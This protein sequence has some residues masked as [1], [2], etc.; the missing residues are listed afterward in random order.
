MVG[1]DAVPT[2]EA[3]VLPAGSAPKESTFQPN[4]EEVV[5]DTSAQPS[6]QDTIM[7]STSGD[8]HTGLGHPGQGQSSYELRHDGQSRD[9]NPGASQQGVGAT[10]SEFKNVDHRD[11]K[12]AHHRGIDKEDRVL[13][14]GEIPSAEEREAQSADNVAAEHSGKDRQDRGT[15]K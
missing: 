1:N 8:V 11:P 5:A 10:T 3:E 2:F 13:G 6:A 14:R 7:G 15:S 9:S 12:F 4:P